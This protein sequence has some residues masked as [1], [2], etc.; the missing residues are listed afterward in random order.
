MIVTVQ[1]LF[2]RRLVL[3]VLALLFGAAMIALPRPAQA[4]AAQPTTQTEAAPAHAGGEADLILPDLSVVSFHGVNGRTLLMGGLVICALGLLF[5]LATF[6][7]LK[8]LPVH[9]SMLEVSELIYATCQTY[10]VTQGKFILLLEVFIGAI[11]VVYFGLLQHL[12]AYRVGIILLF[13]LIGIA[14]GTVGSRLC[15]GHAALRAA[16]AHRAPGHTAAA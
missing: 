10:L 1:T 13:S 14:A 8:A 9:A 15:R 6:A 3:P 5:G 4:A 7:Q 11:M 16:L 12:E 2:R